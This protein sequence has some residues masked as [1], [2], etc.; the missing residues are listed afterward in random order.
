MYNIKLYNSLPTL[1]PATI[2]NDRIVAAHVYPAWTPGE[3]GVHN[4]FF[5]LADYP[6]RTPLGGYYGESSPEVQDVHIKWAL[7]HGINCFIYCW[8]RN[9]NNAGKPVTVN[10]LRAGRGLHEGFLKSSLCDKMKFAIMYEM[11]LPWCGTNAIDIEKNLM[12]FWL[13]NY[14]CRDNY[15]KIDNKP[16]LFIYDN[17]L[18]FANSF[19]KAPQQKACFD[20]LRAIARAHGFDGMYFALEYRKEDMSVL[21]DFKERGYDFTFAYCWEIKKELPDDSFVVTDQLRQNDMRLVDPYF[22]APTASCMWDPS[23]RFHTILKEKARQKPEK[24]RKIWKLRPESFRKLLSELSRRMESAPSDSIASKLIM[25]DNWNEWD[26]GHYILPS[27]EFG[28]K[29]LQ[30]VREELTERDNLPDYRLPDDIGIPYPNPWGDADFSQNTKRL[31][32]DGKPYIKV[33]R[34]DEND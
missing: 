12:P 6:E 15:L 17:S 28:F 29:Y 11:Q 14:F 34:I 16:V 8:Y 7:E 2:K 25:I 26:E 9:G 24:T 18:Q 27:T 3:A 30:A 19:E 4:A 5:D 10:D 22:F 20:K 31:D 13:E 21:D 33:E 32:P 23:P 1:T